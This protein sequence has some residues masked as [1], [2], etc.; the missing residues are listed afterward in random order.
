MEFTTEE[1]LSLLLDKELPIVGKIFQKLNFRNLV[2]SDGTISKQV[3]FSNCRFEYLDL[4]FITFENSLIFKGCVFENAFFHAVS[5]KA[6]FII[7]NCS[8]IKRLDFSC[9]DMFS[10][11]E[12]KE[13]TFNEYVDFFDTFFDEKAEISDCEFKQGTNLLSHMGAFRV[14]P[15]I[16]RNIG[17]LKLDLS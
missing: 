5:I 2:S 17:D 3:I 9:G 10:S 1:E 7:K 6:E 13:T 12:L 8:F 15:I 16:A 4:G 11:F 14:E